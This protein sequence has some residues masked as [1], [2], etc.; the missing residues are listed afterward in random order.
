MNK[1][2][3]ISIAAS[4]IVLCYSTYSR[5]DIPSIHEFIESTVTHSH[6]KLSS[7]QIAELETKFTEFIHALE[8]DC[9]I[10]V[11]NIT[12]ETL[13]HIKTFL[14]TFKKIHQQEFTDI[15]LLWE[16]G[17]EWFFKKKS[18]WTYFAYIVVFF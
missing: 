18:F 1:Q 17:G 5:T 13:E 4:V 3:I 6:S 14:I 15:H 12:S 2:C 7:S 10:S 8:Q 11:D 16:K 9:D